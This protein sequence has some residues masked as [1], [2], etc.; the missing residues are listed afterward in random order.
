MWVKDEIGLRNGFVKW[1]RWSGGFVRVEGLTNGF[2]RVGLRNWPWVGRG[3]D[4]F[5]VDR[6]WVVM[7]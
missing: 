2:V 3:R 1:V 7:M 5:W 4:Q 6:S